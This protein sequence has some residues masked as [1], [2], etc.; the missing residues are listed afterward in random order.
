VPGDLVVD[1]KL[2]EDPLIERPRGPSLDD[3][4]CHIISVVSQP[5]RA[6]HR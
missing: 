5:G 1:G 3:E 6:H 2:L 4:S